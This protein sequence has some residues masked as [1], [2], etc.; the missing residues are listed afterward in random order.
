MALPYVLLIG[1][2]VFAVQLLLC[3][4]ADRGI[5]KAIPV[6]CVE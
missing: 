5:V 2:I 1:I 3:R 6:I 4:R